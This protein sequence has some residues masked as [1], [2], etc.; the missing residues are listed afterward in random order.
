MRTVMLTRLAAFTTVLVTTARVASAD[1][2]TVTGLE[3]PAAPSIARPRHP[4]IAL[5]LSAGGLALSIGMTIVGAQTN[6]GELAV[7]GLVSTAVTPSLGEWY[8]GEYLTWGMGIRAA[9][10]AIAV[11]GVAASACIDDCAQSG[12]SSNGTVLVALGL[13]GYAAGTIYDIGHAS[14]AATAY[15]ERHHHKVV[16]APVAYPTTGGPA[17]GMMVGGSF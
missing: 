17:P 8:S 13:L 15:N 4:G 9:S 14:T 6:N 3:A 1:V 16:V 11:A 12:S 7:G 5:A 10:A 2:P